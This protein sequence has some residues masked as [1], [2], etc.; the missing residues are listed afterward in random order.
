MRMSFK[1]S[2]FVGSSIAAF[3]MAVGPAFAQSRLSVSR[4]KPVIVTGTRVQ[5]MTAADS[6]A[7]ITVLGTDALTKGS[8]TTD[9]RQAL[10]QIVPS[11]T[12]QQFGGDT[13]NLTLS[14]ALRGLS[15]NDTLVLVNGKRRHYTG[16]LQV[17][18]G[19]FTSGS[20]AAD[21]SLIPEAAIDHVEVLLD[22]AA[23]QYG[24]D[25]ISGVVN[26]IL[27]KKSSGGSAS[28]TVGD[29][30]NGGDNRS[31]KG[32]RTY[33]VSYNMGIPLFDKGFVNFTVEKSYTNFTQYGGADNR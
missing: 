27:K 33:D 8:G 16:N 13:A 5:G 20:S 12:A 11:F 9:L 24:T 32:A 22:G 23:A 15:P 17:D 1:Q 26:I 29:Y 25:A 7:P 4:G 19:S 2:L 31:G 6:A 3:A 28:G 30:Y 14:A 18:G 21:I 10:G